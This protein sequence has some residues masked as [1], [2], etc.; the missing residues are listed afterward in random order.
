M[1]KEFVPYDIA[2]KLKEKGFPIPTNIVYATYNQDGKLCPMK[3][4]WETINKKPIAP[5]I[6]QVL[7]WLRKE[8]RLFVEVCLLSGGWSYVI[9]EVAPVR[10][11]DLKIHAKYED[12]WEAAALSGIEYVLDNMI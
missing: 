6:G 12:S 9:R 4:V 11:F 8:K 1:K 7:E 2:V 10:G 3:I 5:T